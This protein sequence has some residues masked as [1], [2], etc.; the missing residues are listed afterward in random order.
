MEAP[1]DDESRTGDNVGVRGCMVS[2]SVFATV[3]LLNL[4]ERET[5]PD[6]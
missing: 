4:G 1:I 3:S 5:L 6:N 2:F